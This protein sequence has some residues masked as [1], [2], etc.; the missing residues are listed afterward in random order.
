LDGHPESLALLK[1]VEELRMRLVVNERVFF[2]AHVLDP[3][4]RESHV[5][6]K[7]FGVVADAE[8]KD[9]LAGYLGCLCN[10]FFLF[11]NQQRIGFIPLNCLGICHLELRIV[12]ERHLLVANK[13]I[14]PI[15]KFAENCAEVS[16]V[17]LVQIELN[18][19][20]VGKLPPVPFI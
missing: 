10:C 17:V 16:E 14:N 2:A 9:I 15:T 20:V 1:L 7:L 8:V 19:C 13:L 12:F 5:A 18:N 4:G 3:N 11:V 6:L